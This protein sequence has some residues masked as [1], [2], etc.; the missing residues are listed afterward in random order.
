GQNSIFN[1]RDSEGCAIPLE[2]STAVDGGETFTLE[3]ENVTDINC[4]N[5]GT[6]NNRRG[7]YRGIVSSNGSSGNQFKNARL[8]FSGGTQVGGI[9]VPA[10]NPLTGTILA[11]GLDPGEYYWL[12]EGECSDTTFDF[13]I[14]DFTANPP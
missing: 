9:H 4:E 5:N 2:V 11:F 10:P 8:F 7:Q 1:I 12:I 13:T 14:E 6:L 3:S